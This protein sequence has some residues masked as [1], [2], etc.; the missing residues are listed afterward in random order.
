MSSSPG[1]TWPL[2]LQAGDLTLRPLRLRDRK[3]WDRVRENN[4]D[5]L[6][7]WEAT[8][9]QVPGEDPSRKLPTFPQMVRFHGDE[10][11]AGRAFNLAIWHKDA[12]V[13]QITLGGIVFGA[14]RG[15]HIGY[16]IDQKAA[17]QGI[18]THAVAVIT[19]FAFDELHLHRIEINLRPENLPSRRVAEKAGY[20]LEG[21]R[22]RFLHIDGAWRDHLCFVKENPGIL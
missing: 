8:R 21:E 3:A 7:R 20:Q 11:R 4:R 5:W 14:L 6:A 17:N 13:G 2:V 19:K 16:W 1:H 12:F 22:P 18:T 15:A 9:P 10:G